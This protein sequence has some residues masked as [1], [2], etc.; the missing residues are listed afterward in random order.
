MNS[1]IETYGGEGGRVATDVAH[2][3][4]ELAFTGLPVEGFVIA[5]ALF[6]GAGL[7]LWF[8]ERD[9]NRFR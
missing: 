7:L 9:K 4:G 2:R 5:A 8:A 3:G 1:S 6:I